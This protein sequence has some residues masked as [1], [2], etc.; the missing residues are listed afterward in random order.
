ML[1]S[2][3]FKTKKKKGK[4]FSYADPYS[5]FSVIAED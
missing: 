4:Q 3:V 2:K 5:I 1:P